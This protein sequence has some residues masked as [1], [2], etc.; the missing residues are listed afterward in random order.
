M[1]DFPAFAFCL[2]VFNWTVKEV[3]VSNIFKIT[4]FFCIKSIPH[5]IFWTWSSHSD[6]K[7][8]KI[9]IFPRNNLTDKVLSSFNVAFCELTGYVPVGGKCRC[10]YFFHLLDNVNQNFKILQHLFDSNLY[11]FP[12]PDTYESLTEPFLIDQISTAMGPVDS[13]ELISQVIQLLF[14]DDTSQN[15]KGSQWNQKQQ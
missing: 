5:N 10:H 7:L 8:V 1:L 4:E 6:Q 2:P 9:F 11:T 13:Q 14:T 12:D 3:V 15:P